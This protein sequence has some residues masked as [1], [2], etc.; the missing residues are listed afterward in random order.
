[1]KTKSLWVLLVACLGYS[2]AWAQGLEATP[3]HEELAQA[4]DAFGLA[5]SSK[6]G[7]MVSAGAL[8]GLLI[9]LLKTPLG[10]SLL[11]GTSS[12]VRFWIPFGVGAVAGVIEKVIGGGSWWGAVMSMLLIALPAITL[13]RAGEVHGIAEPK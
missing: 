12:A 8:L 3:T 7:W 4:A 2:L 5:L 1:M 10:G 6:A 11:A 9:K 13:R